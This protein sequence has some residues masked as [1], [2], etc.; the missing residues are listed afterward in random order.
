MMQRTIEKS[1]ELR[2]ILSEM[3][4]IE[5]EVLTSYTLADAIREGSTV[6][7]QAKHGWGDGDQQCA[8]HAAVT[9]ALARHYLG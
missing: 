9:A 1:E 6:S 8:M 2:E 7:D 3:D 5:M 4:D